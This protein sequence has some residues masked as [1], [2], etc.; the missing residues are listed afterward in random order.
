M[1]RELIKRCTLRWQQDSYRLPNKKRNKDN[2]SKHGIKNVSNVMTGTA[3]EL[4]EFFNSYVIWLQERRGSFSRLTKRWGCFL[5]RIK[6]KL[7]KTHNRKQVKENFTILTKEL[8]KQMQVANVMME[9]MLKT[10]EE[11]EARSIKFTYILLYISWNFLINN[12][13]KKRRRI[14]TRQL[15]LKQFQQEAHK[16]LNKKQKEKQQV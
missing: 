11:E 13:Y 12:L 1:R 6:P 16:H 5:H 8:N 14:L 4:N 9:P 15:P 7:W 10:L 3:M 2:T